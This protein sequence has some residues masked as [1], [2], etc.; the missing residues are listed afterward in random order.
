MTAFTR[1]TEFTTDDPAALR[2]N[3]RTEHHDIADKFAELDAKASRRSVVLV[4]DGQTV[5]AAR[6]TVY[7]GTTFTVTVPGKPS[8]GDVFGVVGRVGCA[9]LIQSSDGASING[10]A[11]DSI[12]GGAFGWYEWIWVASPLAA[13]Q[14]W[15]RR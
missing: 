4:G 7:A 5:P 15:W 13:L 1:N 12:G 3:L 14:G 6:D 10:G 2:L 11:S 9:I 8:P